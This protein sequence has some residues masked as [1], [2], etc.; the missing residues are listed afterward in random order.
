MKNILFIVATLLFLKSSGQNVNEKFDGKKWE[1][2]YVLDT[3]KGWDV[4]RFLIPISFAPAIPYKGVEDIRF[5]PGWAKKT[6]NE[7]WSYAFL[8]YL[9]GTVALDANTIENNLK[10]YYSGLIKVNSDSAKIADKLFPVTSSIRARTTE[11]ED[12]KTFE[13]SVTMLDYM[14][15]QAITLNVVIHVRICAGKDKT[16]VFH[17]L[18]PMPYSDDV[19]KRLHQLWINFKCNKE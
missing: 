15:K 9:E 10:A 5:T 12:L 16:F 1:A 13:G 11:K 6:T 19:W 18:S 3:I 8:W 4:E 2:P 7:Y 14:S 17:E